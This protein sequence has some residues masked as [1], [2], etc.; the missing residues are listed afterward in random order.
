MAKVMKLYIYTNIYDV[1]AV[2]LVTITTL[3]VYHVTVM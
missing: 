2:V 3:T 1:T